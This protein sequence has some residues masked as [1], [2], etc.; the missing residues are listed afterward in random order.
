MKP[1]IVGIVLVKNEEKALPRAL[2]SLLWCDEILVIDAESTDGSV[3]LTLDPTS[4]W[5]NR[6]RVVR[7]PWP[8]FSAQRNFALGQTSATWRFFLDADEAC[9]AELAL[10]LRSI[11]ARVS[12]DEST[13]HYH[14]RRREYFL[15][16]E[17]KHGSW[18]PSYHPRFLREGAG[19]YTKLLH[20]GFE[21]SGRNGR[22][23]AP[24]D[25]WIG[26]TVED[27]SDRVNRYTTLEA[28]RD[29]HQGVRT[30]LLQA[31]LVFP[32]MFIKTYVYF[33]GFKDGRYGFAISLLEGIARMIRCL[34]LWQI[35]EQKK[36][37]G[38]PFFQLW[39]GHPKGN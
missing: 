23:E 1:Q 21:G 24:I 16:R 11:A 5:A 31:T 6:V 32:A 18:N 26:R 15:G 13:T 20:E 39:R 4:P 19:K 35:Q 14:V 17:I 8:G 2:S 34:K 7:N 9:S 29:F 38:A 30:N 27:I 22:I 25:H 12:T 28:E 37:P 33:G 36:V 3:A 10:E